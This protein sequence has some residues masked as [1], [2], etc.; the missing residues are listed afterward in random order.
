MVG[1]TKTEIR[2]EAL[3]D[4]NRTTV[5]NVTKAINKFCVGLDYIW[6]PRSF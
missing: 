6:C 5:E 4:D 2:D 1:E 3:S